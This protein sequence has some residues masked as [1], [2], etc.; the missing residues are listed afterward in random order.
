MKKSGI[1]PHVSSFDLLSRVLALDPKKRMSTNNALMHPYF[2]TKPLPSTDVFS[3]F[4]N[5]PFPNR[6]FLPPADN[7][8]SATNQANVNI[9]EVNIH[10]H[11]INAKFLG[12]INVN[13]NL[14]CPKMVPSNAKYQEITRV[15]RRAYLQEKNY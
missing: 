11:R 3:C 12:Q 2:S 14:I 7:Q 13:P 6:M 15:T 4:S 10:R 8:I 1:D 9:N 5:I